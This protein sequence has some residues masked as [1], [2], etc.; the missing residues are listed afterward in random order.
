MQGDG[1]YFS[2]LFKT[3]ED[4]EFTEVFYEENSLGEELCCAP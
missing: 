3:T 1:I 2:H 4:T